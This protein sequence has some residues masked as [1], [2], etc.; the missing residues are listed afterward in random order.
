MLLDSL[1]VLLNGIT[2]PPCEHG[3]ILELISCF[4]KI[5]KES[6]AT[7]SPVSHSPHLIL[8]IL[9]LNLLPDQLNLLLQLELLIIESGNRLRPIAI[10]STLVDHLVLHLG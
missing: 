10:D 9:Q 5:L 3:L 2:S 7:I 8:Q 1:R 6:S 4:I